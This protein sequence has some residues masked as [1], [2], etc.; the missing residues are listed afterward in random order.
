MPEAGWVLG[1]ARAAKGALRAQW[2][3]EE[4]LRRRGPHPCGAIH[5]MPVAKDAEAACD[6]ADPEANIHG[7]HGLALG[8]VGVAGQKHLCPRLQPGSVKNAAAQ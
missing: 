4:G 7:L 1:E 8:R 6:L 5:P 3:G 2:H